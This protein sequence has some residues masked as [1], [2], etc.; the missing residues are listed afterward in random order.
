MR[1][2]Y[3][4]GRANAICEYATGRANAIC[5]TRIR[6][7]P[8]ECD[9]RYVHMQTPREYDMRYA[10]RLRTMSD[11]KVAFSATITVAVT[12]PLLRI[13]VLATAIFH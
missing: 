3:V 4:V 6:Y 10:N 1:C 2:K 8:R 7:G 12:M 13:K 9:M 5:D 11:C